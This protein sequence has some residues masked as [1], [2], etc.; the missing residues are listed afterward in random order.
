MF[1]EEF[2]IAL[3]NLS[4]A[5]KDK[6]IFR[7][8]KKD[9]KLA[10]KLHFELVDTETV[11]QKRAQVSEKITSY[12][13]KMPNFTRNL[14]QILSHLRSISGFIT[15]HVNTTKDKYGEIALNIQMLNE[16]IEYNKELLTANQRNDGYKLYIYIIARTFKILLLTKAI[17]EDYWMEYREALSNLGQNIG[18]VHPLLKIAINNQLNVN[19]LIDFEIPID[20]LSFH[21]ELR[22]NGFLK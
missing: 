14:K 12:I 9:L 13:E 21:K 15:E 8:I 3:Q 16:I 18:S 11:E 17:N 1:D 22:A 20:I 5:E 19:W 4:I 6:L 10:K 2:K 7:L